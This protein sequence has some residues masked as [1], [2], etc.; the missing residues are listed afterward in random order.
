MINIFYA[1]IFLIFYANINS[2]RLSSINSNTT[3]IIV[4]KNKL[5]YITNDENDNNLYIHDLNTFDNTQVSIHNDNEIKNKILLSLNEENLIIF[6][7][8]NDKKSFLYK[9]YNINDNSENSFEPGN[10]GLITYNS[11][12]NV[13][14]L[15]EKQYFLYFISGN[16]LYIYIDLIREIILFILF[17]N[18]FLLIVIGI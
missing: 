11:Q 5:F 4:K 13:F 14:I 2:E 17:Q 9:I 8:K 10:F 16:F 12:I 6:G 15:N 7:Y 3:P 18:K 1:L